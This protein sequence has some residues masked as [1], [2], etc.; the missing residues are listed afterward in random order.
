MGARLGNDN[1]V[2]DG[3]MSSTYIVG[4]YLS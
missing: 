3:V 2:A 1:P 4:L